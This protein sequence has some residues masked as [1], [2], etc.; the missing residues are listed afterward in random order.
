MNCVCGFVF[1]YNSIDRWRVIDAV[2]LQGMNDT[3]PCIRWNIGCNFCARVNYDIISDGNWSDDLS[4]TRD[5]DAVADARMPTPADQAIR[6]AS[7]TKDDH[8]EEIAV[9]A[10]LRR[11]ANH[12][13][14]TMIDHEPFRYLGS[15][16]NLDA[17]LCLGLFRDGTGGNEEHRVS[18]YA[19][20]T[21]MGYCGLMKLMRYPVVC[22]RQVASVCC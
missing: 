16:M 12:R 15:R 11:F 6:D 4:A 18:K 8:L 14:Y 1:R 19:C 9:G 7:S 21:L 3:D 2:D 5:L 22:H 17:R 13:S 10:D 20:T